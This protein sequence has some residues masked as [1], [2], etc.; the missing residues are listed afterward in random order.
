MGIFSGP[1]LFMKHETHCRG[2]HYTPRMLW[3]SIMEACGWRVEEWVQR[4]VSV[5][6]KSREIKL[7]T[8]SARELL[9]ESNPM[10]FFFILHTFLP[11]A[12]KDG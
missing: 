6:V 10:F 12:V 5:H 8:S 11:W 7:Q 3:L 9:A 2:L 4:C 1:Y